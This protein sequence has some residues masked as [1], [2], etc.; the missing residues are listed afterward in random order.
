MEWNNELVLRFIGAFEKREILWNPRHALYFHKNKKEDAC[1]EIS[2]K[3]NLQVP[4][5]Q[6]KIESLKVPTDARKP[7]LKKVLKLVKVK[8]N[9]Y[10]GCIYNLKRT[11][12]HQDEILNFWRTGTNQE[13]P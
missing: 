3:I 13:I 5:L 11:L 7:E 1:E 6:R 2:K 9:Y 10:L 8:K 4:D 12:F